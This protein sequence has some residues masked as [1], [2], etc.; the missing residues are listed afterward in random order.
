MYRRL[1]QRGDT[2][3]VAKQGWLRA[4]VQGQIR[5]RL[6]VGWQVRVGLGQKMVGGLILHELAREGGFVVGVVKWLG[7]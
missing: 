1:M 7:F 4:G 2:P 3:V 6:G 5:G